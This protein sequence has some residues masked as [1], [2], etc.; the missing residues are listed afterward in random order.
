[1]STPPPRSAP[2]SAAPAEDSAPCS[3][4]SPA[5]PALPFVAVEDRWNKPKMAEFLRM[6]GAT[7]C[8]ASAARA[9]GM[10]WQ[11]AY[12]LRNRLKGEPFDIAWEAAFQHGYDALHQAA[13]ERALHGVEVPVYFN[14]EQIG[15]RRHFDER[16]TIWFLARRNAM[17]RSGSGAT[18]P[19]PSSGRSGGTGC[20]R[21]SSRAT[22]AGSTTTASRCDRTMRPR[23][24]S[25]RSAT[26]STTSKPAPRSARTSE[27]GQ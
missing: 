25:S 21:W 17:G 27:R 3:R 23:S 22:R 12:K 10:S 18:P 2:S 1:M 7:Q 9:V 6:L 20:S 24:A 5:P 13:L 14:G 19:R 11:S 4:G 15:T 26:R 16:L 8:V